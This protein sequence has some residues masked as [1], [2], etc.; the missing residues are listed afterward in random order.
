LA[1]LDAKVILKLTASGI[2]CIADRNVHVF[3]G[4]VLGGIAGYDDVAPRDMHVD[5]HAEQLALPVMLVRGIH[6]YAATD[7]AICEFLELRS[8]LEDRGFDGFGLD[9]IVK[10]NFKRYLHVS[11][12]CRGSSWGAA[13]AAT[14]HKLAPRYA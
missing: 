11:S 7:D 8:A 12:P 13:L 10:V 2:E 5:G 3:V 6:G 4:M 1:A 14:M 9:R